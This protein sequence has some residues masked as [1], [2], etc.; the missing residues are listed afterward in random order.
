MKF[1]D[2]AERKEHCI[3]IHAF[4]KNYR[5]YFNQDE[6]N[7]KSIK[8]ADSGSVMDIDQD[9]ANNKIE[10]KIWFENS[11]QKTFRKQKFNLQKC[12]NSSIEEPKVEPQMKPVTMFVPRQVQQKSYAQKLTQNKVMKKEVLESGSLMELVDSLP[13]A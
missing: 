8:V 13:N 12:T 10:Q 6:T 7:S 4:P 2:S 3:S 9:K 5:F 1:K 11:K